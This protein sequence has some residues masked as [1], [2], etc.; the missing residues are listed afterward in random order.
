VLTEIH[1][2]NPGSRFPDIEKKAEQP[3]DN[4]AE[5]GWRSP[6]PD[7]SAGPR[8]DRRSKVLDCRGIS[9]VVRGISPDGR[10]APMAGARGIARW[11]GKSPT[12]NMAP[13]LHELTKQ[14]QILD[15]KFE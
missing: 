7:L 5:N 8:C 3:V 9:P 1:F 14:L 2:P 11:P 15:K 10:A 12:E 4:S 6:G 13:L